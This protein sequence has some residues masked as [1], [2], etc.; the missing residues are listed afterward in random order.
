MHN[1]PRTPI[2]IIGVG[3]AWR[4][5][6][7]AGLSVA[8]RLRQDNLPQVEI[9]ESPG[10]GGS[11]LEAWKDAARV[12]VVDA[13]VAGGSPGVIYRFDAHDPAA[14]FPV[15][16]SPSSHGWGLSEALALGKVFQDLPPSSLF[17]G[18]KGKILPSAAE[19]S[20]AVGAAIPEAARRIAQ[21]I[22]AWLGQDVLT[23]SRCQ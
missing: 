4:G 2:K 14:T 9:A 22:Q 5:D 17:M 7:A 3:N 8:R 19:L 1:Y 23:I 11:I 16:R 6:D 21:D 12:I 13:V 10:T 18:L 20:P 15:S